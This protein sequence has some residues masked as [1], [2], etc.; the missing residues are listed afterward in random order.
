M[1]RSR[2]EIRMADIFFRRTFVLFL[3]FILPFCTSAQKNSTVKEYEKTYVTYPFSDPDPVANPGKIYPYF[4]YDGFTDVPIQK[5]WKVVEL[6]NDYIKV[7]IM[8]QIGG[9]IWTAIDKKTGKPFLYN[10]DVVKFRDIAMR[11]AWTSGGI[12]AN[13]GIIGHTPTIATPVDYLTR[14]NADGSASCVIGALDLL[15]RSYWNIEIRLPKDKAFFTTNVYWHNT[16]AIEEPYYSWMNLAVKASDSLRFIDPGTHYIGHEGSAHSWPYDSVHHKNLSIYGQNNF[17]GD[18]SYHILGIYSKYYGAYWPKEDFGMI[19][20]AERE[21][22]LGKK[23]FLW[24]LSDEGK[25]WEK[26]LTDNSGQYVEIQ[27]GR[28]FSQNLLKSSFT[29]FKQ[30]GFAPYQADSWKEYWY[31]FSET[32]GVT[33]ADLN[34]VITV[35]QNGDSL[36]ISISPISKISDS[37]KIYNNSS[38]IIFQQKIDLLPLQSYNRTI[39]LKHGEKFATLR[40]QG[41]IIKADEDEK[42]LSRPVETEPDFDWQSAYGLYL[43][44][45]DEARYRQYASAE[46]K[47]RQSLQKESTFIPALTEM[48]YLKY[49]K[50]QYD[51]SFYY[52]KKALTIDTYNPEANYY[53]A[54]A[55]EKSGKFYD[56]LDGFEIACLTYPF[57]SAAYAELSKMWLQK[58]DYEKAYEYASKSLETNEKNLTALQLRYVSARLL[59]KTGEQENVKKEILQIDPLNHFIAFED[60]WKTKDSAAKK[61]F[62]NAIRNELPHQTYLELAIWYYNLNRAEES[63]AILS[64]SPQNNEIQYWL[65][66]LNKE[67]ED[68]NKLLQAADNGNPLMVFPFR[69]ESAEMFKW[70]IQ[71]TN[72]WKPRYYLALIE[73]Y[74]NNKDTAAKLLQN[75]TGNIDFA[76][77]YITRAEFYDSSETDKK[78]NDL[79]KALSLDPNEW[80]YT[81]DL[82][83][84]FLEN[85]E[86][87][88]ALQILEPYFKT[89]PQNYIV[90]MLYTQS[91][92][93]NNRYPEA[94]KILSTIHILPYEGATS[95]RKLYRQTKLM[96]ALEALKK[97]KYETALQKINE[98]DE[99]PYN[100]GVG[101]PYDDQIDT[102]L[103][104]SLRGLVETARKN[105]NRAA[106]Y[107]LYEQKIKAI[108]QER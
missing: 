57:R 16:T 49:R 62:C 91:L 52:A 77:F 107:D 51:S 15:T 97:N 12:E 40:L 7:Q 102:Q 89:H 74:R 94:E 71:H 96:L 54:L 41:T 86:N 33:N 105:K 82:A 1:I 66:F 95:G 21:D 84:Y 90:G 103:E 36:S 4:R 43:M 24:S 87:Q 2:K 6:E 25:I 98:A 23:V 18:K 29:P 104:D 28:L 44:G 19:H 67:E 5:Q 39:G 31:P 69:E 93:L 45:R 27:S 20:Y 59:G 72:D 11:G 92:M 60:F 42:Q 46:D 80:R 61:A 34:G 79:Q 37:L 22:K 56:A 10:N 9:K 73:S 75:I 53:Y 100:L 8:P 48:A 78:Q 14:I 108:T 99:W 13:F 26:L 3:I 68:A 35:N 32:G 30:I 50:M 83:E 65:A 88:K 85:K 101:K 106:N 76:P 38:D 17:G 47:I 55:A 81:K 58:K 63:K 70:A 64:M